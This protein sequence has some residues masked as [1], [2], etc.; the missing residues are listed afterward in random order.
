MR[1]P[2][3]PPTARVEDWILVILL[4]IIIILLLLHASI[5]L[6]AARLFMGDPVRIDDGH[7]I[8]INGHKLP[9][10]AL[11]FLASTP[12][13]AAWHEVVELRVVGPLVVDSRRDLL[14]L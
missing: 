1:R 13:S 8:P 7:L 11:A 4:F 3:S 9:V 12:P 2:V 14:N 5:R 6:L 10:V